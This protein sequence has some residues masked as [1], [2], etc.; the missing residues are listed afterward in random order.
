[1]SSSSRCTQPAAACLAGVAQQ[2][3]E[4]R[5]ADAGEHV[6]P[7]DARA[8]GRD[9]R[10]QGRVAGGEAVRAHELGDAVELEQDERRGPV[11]AV[12]AADLVGEPVAKGLHRAQAGERV[13]AVQGDRALE[14]GDAAAR[15]L[16]LARQLVAFAAGGHL[17][18]DRQIGLVTQALRGAGRG[19]GVFGLTYT[20]RPSASL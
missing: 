3:R 8:Q 13:A 11:V 7:A 20:R 14:L 12:G 1:M 2:Q 9:D 5:V 18:S 17:P 15:A 4:L 6:L 16:E 10:A 19:Y